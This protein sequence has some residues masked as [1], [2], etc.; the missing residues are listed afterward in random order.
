MQIQVFQN[1]IADTILSESESRIQTIE[2]VI[3]A[4]QQ[5]LFFE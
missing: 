1:L 4:L 3:R 5:S 2:K